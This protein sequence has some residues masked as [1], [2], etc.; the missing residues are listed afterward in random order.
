LAYTGPSIYLHIVNNKTRQCLITC[1]H[2][3]TI[4]LGGQPVRRIHR[5][6]CRQV[7]DMSQRGSWCQV[8]WRSCLWSTKGLLPWACHEERTRKR[9]ATAHVVRIMAERDSLN[10]LS[11]SCSS[12]CRK[13]AQRST[14]ASYPFALCR[15]NCPRR[16]AASSSSTRK[17]RSALQ[18]LCEAAAP[19]PSAWK[20]ARVTSARQRVQALVVRIVA[21][22]ETAF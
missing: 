15:R 10:L 11:R 3:C 21:G 2:D 20:H 14:R 5:S 18:H 7:Y 12:C 4:L 1:E 9:G 8:R 16:H 13:S 19:N 6:R 22:G 17:L